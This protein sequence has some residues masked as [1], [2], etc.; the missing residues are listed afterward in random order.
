MSSVK[1]TFFWAVTAKGIQ[2]SLV[3]SA[4]S[5][6]ANFD[7]GIRLVAYDCDGAEVNRA[8]IS[9]THGAACVFELEYLMGLMKLESGMRHGMMS[10]DYP[11]GA[12]I[13]IRYQTPDTTT[14]APLHAPVSNLKQGLIPITCNPERRTLLALSNCESTQVQVRGRLVLGKRSPETNWTLEPFSSRLVEVENT[15]AAALGEEGFLFSGRGYLRLSTGSVHGVLAHTL[16]RE[17]REDD[18]ELLQIFQD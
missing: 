5:T 6:E 10:I 13:L 7:Q 2:T 4:T 16:V 12:N 9:S 1:Q 17:Q 18:S 14:M 3:V 15:F 11:V 8:E